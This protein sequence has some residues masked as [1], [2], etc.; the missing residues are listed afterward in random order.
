M[1]IA[2]DDA[3]QAG[4]GAAPRSAA[5]VCAILLAAG[6][7]RRMR[8][9]NKLQLMVDG[10]PLLRR[11]ARVLLAS[12]L[13][14]VLVVTGHQRT[15]AE[16][17]L[18]DL[19]IAS[20]HNENYVDGQMSS[21]HKGLAALAQD[22]D[23]V[24]ICLAD[25]PLLETA[26]I[27]FLIDAFARRQRG[28][29]L[30]PTYAGQRGNPIILDSAQRAVILAGGQNLGCKRLIETHPELVATVEMPSRHVVVD[31]DTPEDYARIS[32]A[33]KC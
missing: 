31:M 25:Q 9:V 8:G 4:S 29:I 24:M 19:P 17:L 14:H 10:E 13:E 3:L 2:L 5:K 27:N 16:A 7:S 12:K 11:T 15:V 30:V 18:D 32:G 26:D 28:A 23:G 6:E 21:V 20:V 33:D 22:C 1:D